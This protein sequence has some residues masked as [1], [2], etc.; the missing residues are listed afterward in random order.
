MTIGEFGIRYFLVADLLKGD[1]IYI[2]IYNFVLIFFEANL[3]K[4]DN[5]YNFVLIFFEAILFVYLAKGEK[6]LDLIKYS[7]QNK[8]MPIK[9]H[10]KGS[11]SIFSSKDLVI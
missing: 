5:I 8:R 11:Y 4:G 6:K 7:C 9:H 1:N 2:Y 10:V 3:L